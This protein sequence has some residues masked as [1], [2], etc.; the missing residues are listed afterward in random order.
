M[1][2]AACVRAVAAWVHAVAA[3]VRAVA[4]WVL[5]VAAWVHAV[6]AGCSRLQVPRAA[7]LAAA[8]E[9]L[10]KSKHDFALLYVGK[11]QPDPVPAQLMTQVE[12]G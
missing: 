3:R 6:A 12:E 11:R 7:C 9:M 1:R 2:A 8:V 4:A 5:A 10:S